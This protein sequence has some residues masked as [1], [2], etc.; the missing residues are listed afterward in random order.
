MFQEQPAGH[1]DGSQGEPARHRMEPSTGKLRSGAEARRDQQDGS[2]GFWRSLP[3]GHAEAVGATVAM[4]MLV[5]PGLVLL[6]FALTSLGMGISLV[7]IRA[8]ALYGQKRSLR[9]VPL[10][11]GFSRELVVVVRVSPISPAP[12]GLPA[13]TEIRGVAATPV[14][15]GRESTAKP[16]FIAIR[17]NENDDFDFAFPLNV[18]ETLLPRLDRTMGPE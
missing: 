9:R 4:H 15:G 8:L 18:V 14:A 11:P 12:I 5:L 13:D 2:I 3:I 7:P 10:R 16:D 1:E 6:P 17:P